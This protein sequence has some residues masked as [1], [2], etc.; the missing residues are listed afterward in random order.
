MRVVGPTILDRYDHR[1]VNL[2]P[3]WLPEYPGLHSI[4]RAFADHRDQTGVTVHYIDAGLDSGPIIAQRHVPI[5]ADDTLDSLESRVHE[6]EHQ[7]YPQVLKAVL[8]DLTKK[9]QG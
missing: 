1:I 3:A 9:E 2:H 7:L 4:E 6:V 8:T 5:L